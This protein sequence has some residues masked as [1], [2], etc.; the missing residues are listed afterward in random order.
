MDKMYK[1]K[2]GANMKVIPEGSLEW[3]K[4]AR[5]KIFGRLRKMIKPIPKRMLV[6]S[7]TI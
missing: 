1:V 2:S 7:A 4:K 6:N 3:Y 5:Y